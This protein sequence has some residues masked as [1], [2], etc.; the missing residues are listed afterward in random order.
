MILTWQLNVRTLDSVSELRAHY[1]TTQNLQHFRITKNISF[2]QY[3]HFFYNVKSRIISFKNPQISIQI[4]QRFVY[5]YLYLAYN[6]LMAWDFVRLW[7]PFQ[8]LASSDAL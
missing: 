7:L 6:D 5:F 4:E 1:S 2:L 8:V 3:I